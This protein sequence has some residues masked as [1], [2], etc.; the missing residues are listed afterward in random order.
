MT[1]DCAR[2]SVTTSRGSQ[3]KRTTCKYG[4][5][6]YQHT[7]KTYGVL[8]KTSKIPNSGSGLFATRDF[9]RGDLIV[10]Y[11]GKLLSMEEYEQ[12]EGFYALSL[13]KDHVVDAESTQSS[14]GRYANECRSSNKRKGDC[15][16][17]NARF[18]ISQRNKTTKIKAQSAHW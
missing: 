6:C 3:C 16:G 12:K 10:P 9:K 14:V 1:R 11:T 18:G 15:T 17:I 7:R 13:T 8:V 2:C 4:G 5:M